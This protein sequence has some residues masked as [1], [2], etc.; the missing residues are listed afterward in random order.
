MNFSTDEEPY[1]KSYSIDSFSAGSLFDF[2]IKIR[3][4]LII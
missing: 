4:L 3:G 2:L 1:S